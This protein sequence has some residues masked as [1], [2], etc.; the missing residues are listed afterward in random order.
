MSRLETNL[1]P[2]GEQK[3]NALQG[4]CNAQQWAIKAVFW[5]VL[6]LLPGNGFPA[7]EP[8]LV[9]HPKSLHS[10]APV[11]AQATNA[12]NL[13]A[14][15]SITSPAITVTAGDFVYVEC[16]FPAGTGTLT[17]TSSP[18][19]TWNLLSQSGAA[20]GDMQPSYALNVAGG[21]TT[22]TCT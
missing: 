21:S 22:F 3:E 1:T 11:F 4:G 9:R 14:A 6:V 10:S 8:Q 15:T 18:S 20:I 19:N 7:Q 13:S 16:V 5:L 17:V 2:W 12:T